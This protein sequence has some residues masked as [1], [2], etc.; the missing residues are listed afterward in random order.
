ML[1]FIVANV[2]VD[3]IVD[4]VDV[5]LLASQ[6]YQI[7]THYQLHLRSTGYLLNFCE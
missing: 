4:V 1:L 6:G 3:V 5:D 2:T 7:G